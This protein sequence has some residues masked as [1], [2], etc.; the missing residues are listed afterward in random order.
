MCR[1]SNGTSNGNEV[2]QRPRAAVQEPRDGVPLEHFRRGRTGHDHRLLLGLGARG[3]LPGNGAGAQYDARTLRRPL[4]N[5]EPIPLDTKY[6][7]VIESD[8]PVVVQH[9]RL[10]PR[11]AE[12]ALV[13]AIAYASDE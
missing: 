7:S 1:A 4:T 5:P 10:D 8:V 9:A 2:V 6:A 3:P 12:N 13:S 11:R